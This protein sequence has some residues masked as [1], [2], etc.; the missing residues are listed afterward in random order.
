[1]QKV[2]LAIVVLVVGLILAGTILPDVV[3]DVASDSYSENY[4]VSTGAGVTNTTQELSYASYYDDLT[5]I[6]A[7][8]DNESDTPVVM[9]YDSDT[10][11]VVVDGLV[12]S[13]SRI[14]TVTY[15]KDA[16][17]EYTGFAGFVRLVPFI[18][19]IGLVVAGIWSLFSWWRSR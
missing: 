2:F 3:T 14:L 7:T 1:M 13:D 5:G 11:D 12:E 6:S 19:V 18:V 16:H 17:T 8:S 15:L 9:S 10:Y 4:N